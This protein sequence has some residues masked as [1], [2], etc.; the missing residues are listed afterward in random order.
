MI[1]ALLIQR[2]TSYD[3][4]SDFNVAECNYALLNCVMTPSRYLP[5]IN[6]D[7]T[8]LTILYLHIRTSTYMLPAGLFL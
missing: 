6:I 3:S 1:V 2:I 7:N 5:K 4:W 8:R